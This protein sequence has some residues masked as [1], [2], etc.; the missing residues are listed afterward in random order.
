MPSSWKKRRGNWKKPAELKR[1]KGPLIGYVG[2]LDITR[3]DLGL[4]MTVASE[5]PGWNL[6]FIGSMHKSREIRKLDKFSNVHFL[7]VRVY[8]D[9]LRYIRHFDV[10]MIPHL[11]SELTRSMN[12]LKLYVYFSLHVPV[13][14][15]P[16]ANI[17]DFRE[18]VQVGRTP[19]EFIE[20]IG[21]CLD[22]N[23]VSGNI[24]RVRSLLETNSWNERVT[25]IL[26]LV[27]KEFARRESTHTGPA[28]VGYDRDGYTDCCTVCGHTGYLRR[29]ERSIRET[30]QCGYCGASL[31]YREQARLILRHFSRDNSGHLTELVRE[32]GF[33]NLKIYE[34]GLIG[35]F[36]KLF[37]Q[38]PG[39]CNSYFWEDVQPGEFREEVQ[40]Q[41]LMNLTYEGNSFDL[42]LS[43]DIFEHVRKPFVGFREVNRVLKPGG[44]HI[45]SIP[46]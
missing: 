31:R 21:Y 45:F 3:I 8:D 16:V 19:D 34:P 43:S 4:L 9:A 33:Q 15:T 18:V 25:R 23:P 36:R 30:Y 7:G 38:L 24:E 40:C 37:H 10:A 6:V 41:D 11:D 2:N 32:S 44:F 22:N 42:V 20:R 14:S 28:A 12:P 27:G 35:P 5:R 46:Y 29:E 13:V 26:A 1:I 39:Y 17:G